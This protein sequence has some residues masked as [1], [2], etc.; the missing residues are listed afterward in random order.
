VH[1]VPIHT[2]LHSGMS[3]YLDTQKIKPTQRNTFKTSASATLTFHWPRQQKPAQHRRKRKLVIPQRGGKSEHLL[4]VIYRLDES[5]AL[6]SQLH[7]LQGLPGLLPS[8]LT[9]LW[10]TG[11][12][13]GMQSQVC[14]PTPNPMETIK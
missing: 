2:P 4:M 1:H 7:I 13:H 3:G 9:P 10:A 14:W 11:L 6:S 8:L 12:G 5:L